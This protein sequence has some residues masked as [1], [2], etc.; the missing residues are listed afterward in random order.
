MKADCT[1][2]LELN[3]KYTKAYLRRARASEKS[4]DLETALEDITIAGCLEKFSNER[5]L[6][7]GDRILKQIG[8]RYAIEYMATNKKHIMQSKYVI[9]GYI[10]T[11]PNDPVFRLLEN[12]NND[13]L[14][15]GFRKALQAVKEEKYDDVIPLCTEELKNSESDTVPHKM[16]V[17]LLRGSFLLLLGKHTEALKDFEAVIDS[18]TVPKA[19]KVNALIKRAGLYMQLE[20]LEKTFQ[21]FELA[22]EIDPE[23]GDIYHHRGRVEILTEEEEKAKKDFDKAIKLNPNCGITHAQKYYVDY[24]YGMK[25]HDQNALSHVLLDFLACIDKFPDCLEC[26]ILLSQVLSSM[27]QYFTAETMLAK[28]SEKNPTAAIIYVHRGLMQLQSG[29]NVDE[30]VQYIKKA[31]E[32]DDKCEYAYETLGTIEVQRGNFKEGMELYDKALELCRSLQELTH[33][34]GLKQA[35]KTQTTIKERLGADLGFIL[36]GTV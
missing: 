16:E 33:I 31:L 19:L 21:D 1:K 30:V 7:M 24:R 26:Y 22:A 23:C 6:I 12:E 34:F 2:A 17:L 10:R 3:P 14:S 36:Q 35:A 5:T 20:E 27:Q 11:L 13:D 29:S 25:I 32:L 18:N 28:A 15:P 9:K 4:N 8:K